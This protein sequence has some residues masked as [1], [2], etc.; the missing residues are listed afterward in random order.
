M[1]ARKP[2]G[3]E[4]PLDLSSI[5]GSVTAKPGRVV[6]GDDEALQKPV[7]RAPEPAPPV[8]A[9]PPADIEPPIA[10]APMKPVMPSP[11]PVARPPR[12]RDPVVPT[13]FV[14]QGNPAVIKQFQLRLPEPLKNKLDWVSKHVAHMSAHAL[15]VEAIEERLQRELDR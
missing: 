12:R 2:G 5:I 1:S 6:V 14:E 7:E 3:V 13:G 4:P 15:I 11:A 10:T 8:Q 9:P